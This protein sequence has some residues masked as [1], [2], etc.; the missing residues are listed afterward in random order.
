[1]LVLGLAALVVV[2]SGCGGDGDGD[3]AASDAPRQEVTLR[4]VTVG[5][6]GNESVGVVTTFVAGP[7]KFVQ[8][9]ANGGV[10]RT[11]SDAPPAP[12]DCF[13]LGGVDEEYEIGE[14]E[15]TV[16][17]Y[18]AFLNTVDPEGRNE[19]ALYH[20]YMNPQVWPK[21][22]SV[23][24]TEDADDGE[25]YAIAYPEW[26]NKPFGFANFL[27]AAHF[28]NSLFNGDV[29]SKQTSTSDGF[30]ITTYTV[31]LGRESEKGMYDLTDPATERTADTGF[32]IPSNDEWIKAAYYDPEGGGRFSY[33][34]Y[35]T[36]PT[37]APN[38]SKLDPGTGDVVNAST[39]PL[40]TYTPQAPRA[41]EGS[42]PTWCPASAGE[43]ACE[44]DN[45]Y[46]LPP[47]ITAA[48]FQG[49]VSTVGQTKTR[50]PWGTLDMGGNV[51]EWQD[52]IVP[53]FQGFDFKRTWRRMHGGIA[54]AASYQLLI[55]AIGFQPQN[56]ALLDSVYP[57]FGFRVGVIGELDG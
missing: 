40:S 36:G 44:G 17:Q 43:Q 15:V 26:E 13:D 52:T 2:A 20:D 39:Q 16:G 23:A 30:G 24:Y 11:C 4:M 6:P 48:E 28:V 5:D 56:Q 46:S 34:Q 1:L 10:Y 35:P 25:H 57:W 14:L 47:G 33:W 29:L 37:E 50:S 22:G 9:P 19:R 7:G 21:Y 8:I 45:P 54:N 31:R 12:P 27:R 38:A 55:S 3:E 53:A 51:V 42:Y 18:V 41:P 49:N 32:V